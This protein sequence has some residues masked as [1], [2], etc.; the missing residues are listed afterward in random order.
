VFVL[1]CIVQRVIHVPSNR[2]VVGERNASK[3]PV[4]GMAHAVRG[5]TVRIVRRIVRV[6]VVT[7]CAP[8]AKHAA[9]VLVIADRVVAMV[10][11]TM[12]KRVRAARRIV[13]RVRYAR[14]A[15]ARLGKIPPIARTIVLQNAAMAR[16][17]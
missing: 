15:Y 12:A 11:A 13:A 8:W 2:K 7:N 14:T 17:G 1:V 4:V 3:I 16:A 10:H 5:K 9:I 6:R